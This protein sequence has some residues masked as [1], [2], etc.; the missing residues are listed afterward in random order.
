[1]IAKTS[2]QPKIYIAGHRGMVGGAIERTVRRRNYTNIVTRTHAELPL[3]DRAQVDA[4]FAAEK[5]DWVFLAAAKVGGIA[6]ND[7]Q[8]ADFIR[9][10]LLIQTH[11]IDA[12]WRNGAQRLL[13]LGSSCIY[14]REARQPI[15]EDSLLTGRLEPT[16]S[17]YAVAKIAGKEMCDAYRKQHGFDAFTAMPSNVYGIGDNFHPE[18][19]H[20]IAGMMRRFHEAKASGAQ[21]VVIWGTGKPMRE[22][23]FSEDLGDACLFLMENYADGGMI[24][25]GSGEE[26][27]IA[28]LAKMIG[29]VVGFGGTIRFDTDRPDGTMRKVMDNS[30]ILALGW[31]PATDLRNGLAQMY[32]HFRQ[33]SETGNVR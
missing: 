13:F 11:V 24:N 25:A 5:P 28:E 17:A 33:A 18:H 29:E 22:F 12:A 14:P 9:E 16:N 21:D 32:D 10:N 4:F 23:I 2:E 27:S 3:D 31:K 1:M 6:A 20:V 15:R 30:R 7:T 26:V 8:P 19:S